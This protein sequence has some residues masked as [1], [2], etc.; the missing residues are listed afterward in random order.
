MTNKKPFTI[1]FIT[2]FPDFFSSFTE[3]SVVKKAREK[4]IIQFKT[5]NLSQFGVGKAKKVDDYQFGPGR[6]MVLR[7]EPIYQ[8]I[9][10]AEKMIEGKSCKILLSA[11]GCLFN[12]KQALNLIKNYQGLILIA[13]N[14]E[15]VDERV[16]QYVDLEVSIGNFVLTG[17][18]IPALTVANVTIRLLEGF[19]HPESAL[20]ESFMNNLLD[21]PVYTQP[22]LFKGK[23]VPD[24]LLSGHHKKILEWRKK[25]A[26]IKTQ[27]NNPQILKETDD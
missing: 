21:Y 11:S 18:E 10:K 25:Q 9:K 26:L 20:N 22:R 12:Q 27:K 15:G 14:Y 1:V 6:G 23:K 16:V 8:A 3:H 19:I 2:L 7:P 4:K 5:I 17:G 13:G 24:I